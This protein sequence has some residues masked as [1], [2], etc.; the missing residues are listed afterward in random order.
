MTGPV[1]DKFSCRVV[2]DS[3][4]FVKE[5]RKITTNTKNVIMCSFDIVNLF[6]NIPLDETVSIYANTLFHT[7]IIPS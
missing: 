4:S 3:F 1:L 6:T 2:T 5:L 7:D